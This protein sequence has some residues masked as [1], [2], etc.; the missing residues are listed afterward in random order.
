M[1]HRYKLG[2]SSKCSLLVDERSVS[3]EH[4]IF[5]DHGDFLKIEDVSRNG[6]WLYRKS[7]KRKLQKHTVEKLKPEDIL[8]FGFYEQ[9]FPAIEI[10]SEI[11]KL[12]LPVGS[13]HIRCPIHGVIY[14]QGKK[15]PQCPD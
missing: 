6:T 9:E 12:R 15:C 4:A 7:V 14:M 10:L 1:A 8:R 13:Q 2:R 11:K 3:L 5:I